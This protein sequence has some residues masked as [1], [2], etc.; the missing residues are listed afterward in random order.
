MTIREIVARGT[1]L[2]PL[3]E[4]K[5]KDQ[6]NTKSSSKDKVE[7]SKEARSLYEADR[8]KRI[9]ELREKIQQG[10]YFTQEV[11]EK[12]ADAVLKDLMK[13]PAE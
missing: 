9:E 13:P 12:V 5:A 8:T 10:F 2:D 11:T 1:P 4:K 6:E 3:K 7:L